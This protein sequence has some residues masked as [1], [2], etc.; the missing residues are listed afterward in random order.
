MGIGESIMAKTLQAL[1][2][3]AEELQRQVAPELY[4][5][6]TLSEEQQETVEAP[7]REEVKEEVKAEV[8]TPDFETEYKKLLQQENSA[9]GRLRVVADENRLLKEQLEALSHTVETLKTIKPPVAEVPTVDDGEAKLI[10][11]W[12]E[13]SEIVD[14][15]RSQKAQA[16]RMERQLK[17]ELDTVKKEVMGVKEVAEM[18]KRERYLNSLE[19][20]VSEWETIRDNPGFVNFLQNQAP[21]SNDTLLQKLVE[22]DRSND[23]KVVAQIYSA[24]RDSLNA[25]PNA[26]VEPRK[27]KAALVSPGSSSRG[28]DV[29]SKNIEILQP[30]EI[31]ALK[32]KESELRKRGDFKKAEAIA[33]RVD[34]YLDNL[35]FG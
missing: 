16:E 4:E 8:P 30:D 9:K 13:D 12:G 17:S 22:A 21:F 10:D 11:R 28:G 14:L 19:S 7:A 3:E 35:T 24:F 15:Y 27:S 5:G 29:D 23:V 20:Q 18:S 2:T 6:E 26:I 1:E 32:V 25:Q 33:A 31:R 34:A